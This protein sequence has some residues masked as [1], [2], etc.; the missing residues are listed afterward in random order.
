[1]ARFIG[2]AL[3]FVV[4]ALAEDLH[5]HRDLARHHTVGTVNPRHGVTRLQRIVASHDVGKL[6][7]DEELPVLPRACINLLGAERGT[8]FK[9]RRQRIEVPAVRAR[10]RVS[11]DARLSKHQLRQVGRGGAFRHAGDLRGRPHL[12]SAI[13]VLAHYLE[14]H[15]QLVG[16]CRVAVR[17]V[18]PDDGV[19][20]FKLDAACAGSSLTV[21]EQSPTLIR[22]AR[23]KSQVFIERRRDALHEEAIRRVRIVVGNKT[24]LIE[25]LD[26]HVGSGGA[27]CQLERL[28]GR[29]SLLVAL[30]VNADNR[31]RGIDNGVDDAA[32]ADYGDRRLH[33]LIRQLCIRCVVGIALGVAGELLAGKRG[34]DGYLRVVFRLFDQQVFGGD[35]STVA[36]FEQAPIVAR[37]GIVARQLHRHDSLASRIG[38]HTVV[39]PSKVAVGIKIGLLEGMQ[40]GGDLRCV[41]AVQNSLGIAGLRL[42]HERQLGVKVGLRKRGH[43][44]VERFRGRNLGVG[45]VGDGQRDFRIRGLLAGLRLIHR[46]L[47]TV[48]R[49]VIGA[50]RVLHLIVLAVDVEVARGRHLQ[51]GRKAILVSNGVGAVVLYLVVGETGVNLGL[52]RGLFGGHLLG[53]AL[54][55]NGEGV[56]SRRLGAV[57][58]AANVRHEF[59]RG[60]KRDGAIG[61]SA[62]HLAAV[63]APTVA[64]N[65]DLIAI[66][67]PRNLELVVGAGA[68]RQRK[69]TGDR[70]G[71]IARCK[72]NSQ[73]LRSVVKQL[74]KHVLVPRH[75]DVAGLVVDRLAVLRKREGNAG[76]TQAVEGVTRVVV[77][78]HV[79]VRDVAVGVLI[80]GDADRGLV[81]RSGEACRL[82]LDGNT[83]EAEFGDFGGQHVVDVRVFAVGGRGL[84]VGS[85]ELLR[86]S[87]KRSAVDNRI[88][89]HGFHARGT[90]F[91]NYLEVLARGG[92]GN[93]DAC[94]RHVF[95]LR[96][97]SVG[98]IGGIP[99]KRHAVGN[100][101]A[102]V[103]IAVGTDGL[104]LRGD[105]VAS[106]HVRGGADG[107]RRGGHAQQ[108]VLAG[109][110]DRGAR[111]PLDGVV[112]RI[113]RDLER[114]ADE[115]F[116][117]GERAVGG[118]PF[119]HLLPISVA[120]ALG[121]P[122][123]GELGVLG[124]ILVVIAAGNLGLR[125]DGCTHLQQSRVSVL[126][127]DS[128]ERVLAGD[129][130]RTKR[131]D[132]CSAVVAGLLRTDRGAV[133]YGLD[134]QVLAHHVVGNLI[135]YA[136]SAGDV[137]ERG[138][139]GGFGV[140]VLP[141]VADA[142]SRGDLRV[143]ALVGG[144]SQ[145]GADLGRA[146]DLYLI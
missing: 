137:L 67:F 122:G 92:V 29:P 44:V 110:G 69:V 31:A 78:V 4:R 113:R 140:G 87:L 55:R 109:R 59:D 83:F 54:D 51:V 111:R 57:A 130:D 112:E 24:D 81:V 114:F 94:A 98:R 91:G 62:H 86:Q 48:E 80:G 38:G 7:V 118:N 39:A 9:R 121:V 88:G 143:A 49:H 139:C 142:V 30:R 70:I 117:D 42:L 61:C 37:H 115:R 15:G 123:V 144:S 68:V 99:G 74:L 125:G 2:P 85:R 28:R 35:N 53:V 89:E 100:G 16:R 138:L 107:L 97:R 129:G 21:Y 120:F 95:K 60:S 23:N 145:R 41:L 52:Q 56:R 8:A 103:G 6:A 76:R 43:R 25:Q 18:A 33:L 106:D 14:G 64:G 5:S 146:G 128:G 136:R 46:A 73:I 36:G 124:G 12:L 66:R 50:G 108:V 90:A 22:R 96:E 3:G 40:V 20:L 26:G 10:T 116:P 119:G 63:V 133:A 58:A 71:R 75:G 17:G 134:A 79:E 1:M 131:V 77:R 72:S 84:E 27:V 102:R 104:C 127:L 32:G 45:L 126:Q 82:D 11:L 19:A 141:L 135:S 65:I 105:G 93:G 101:D 47:I 34:G 13:G 132:G